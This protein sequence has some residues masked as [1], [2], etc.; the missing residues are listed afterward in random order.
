MNMSYEPI[1][2]RHVMPGFGWPEAWHLIS[3]SF[4]SA[5]STSGGLIENLGGAGFN[6]VN[7]REFE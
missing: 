2:L 5:T 7:S 3:T 1:I 4:P 6:L